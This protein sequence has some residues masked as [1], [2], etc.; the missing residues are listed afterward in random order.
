MRKLLFSDEHQKA[1]IEKGYA[2]VK[3]LTSED[4]RYLLREMKNLKPDDNFALG[5]ERNFH[6]TLSDTSHGYRRDA[7]Q[8]IYAAFSPHVKRMFVDCEILAYGFSIKTPG[9][10]GEVPVHQDWT[11]TYDSNDAN[12]NSWCPLANVEEED[13][14]LYVVEGSH[15]IAPNIICP[16]VPQ[17]VTDLQPLLKQLSKPILLQA[18]EALIWDPMLIHWS[19]N[20]NSDKPRVA[21]GVSVVPRETRPVFYYPEKDSSDR[22]LKVFEIDTDFFIDHNLNEILSGSFRAASIGSI[23]YV[24]RQIPEEEFLKIFENGDEIKRQSASDEKSAT[25]NREFSLLKK[26]RNYLSLEALR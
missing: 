19:P 14:A 18:G 6:T 8:L 23:A 21:A 12:F 20:N 16:Q 22:R 2:V 10:K 4:V 7:Y 11:V 15:R 26:I 1:L 13:G 9:G 5:G 3:M 24:N 17:Y 25:S